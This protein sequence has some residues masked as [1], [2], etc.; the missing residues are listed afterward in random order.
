MNI[1]ALIDAD[2]TLY[3]SCSAVEKSIHWG[4]DQWTLHADA[5]EAREMFDLAIA[6]IRQATK[7]TKVTLA[8]S[9]PSN[10][11]VRLFPEY[12]AN[13]QATRKPVCYSEVKRYANEA[14]DCVSYP[15]LEGD[16]VI[17][18]IATS[19][20]PGV[21]FIMVSED[22]DFQTIPGWHYNPRT[23]VRRRVTKA[24]AM[25]ALYRQT[26]T[27]DTTDNYKGLPGCGPVKADK[28]LDASCTWEA[29]AAAFIAAGLTEEDALVQARMAHILH[30]GEYDHTTAEV[31]LWTPG[32]KSKTP[33]R[34]KTSR[35][36]AA[37]TP[38]PARAASIS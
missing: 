31:K 4:D 34:A 17:G 21:R 18:M 13:R 7:A 1:H 32:T 29:V 20:R 30:H 19:K 23:D 8:F 5:A 25:R 27:G 12:K 2:I 36:A 9:S 35:P 26:L 15:G 22:K 38:E 28:I 3:K 37:A 14:Y 10:F 6:D 24:Q 16:D 11:R 33:A